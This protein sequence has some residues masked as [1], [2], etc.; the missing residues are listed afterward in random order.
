MNAP[1]CLGAAAALLALG[2]ASASAQDFK[3]SY[4]LRPGGRVTVTNMSG[5][6]TVRGY[7]GE[8]V[9]V[10]GTR[11]GADAEKVE[12]EDNSSGN[13]VDL[14]VRYPRNCDCDASVDFVVQ[15]PRSASFDFAKIASMSGDVR[16]EGVT[17]SV[18]ATA[19]SGDVHVGDVV[20]T[21]EATAMSGDLEVAVTRLE[22][23]GDL[24][25]TSMS[26]DVVVRLPEGAGAD[27]EIKTTS[28]NITTDFPIQVEEKK[29]GP[30][31]TA[32]GRIGDGSRALRITSMSGDVRFLRN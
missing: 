24:K 17:G 2:A 26:G 4:D 31:Q 15:V 23:E 22:G 12:I 21:V 29:F 25:F 16:I 18:R 6:V 27:V 5:D 20:G 11:R 32:R 1:F 28:G 13:E 30:G 14:G 19:M 9:V 3:K 8:S 10:T 7:D